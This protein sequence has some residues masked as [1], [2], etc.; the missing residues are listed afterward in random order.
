MRTQEIWRQGA[1]TVKNPAD[2]TNRCGITGQG[3]TY[4]Y[5]VR[6]WVPSG[7]L[8][9]RGFIVDNRAI[10][11]YWVWK[12]GSDQP[13]DVPSCEEIAERACQ[14]FVKL[15]AYEGVQLQGCEIRLYG[16]THSAVTVRWGDGVWSPATPIEDQMDPVEEPIEPGE[17]ILA[18]LERVLNPAPA[19]AAD[20]DAMLPPIDKLV[21]PGPLG[22][23]PKPAAEPELIPFGLPV[24]AASGVAEEPEWPHVEKALEGFYAGATKE[25]EMEPFP[26]SCEL[27][28]C[29]PT[30]QYPL[31]QRVG[32]A[33]IENG[34][35]ALLIALLV[36]GL[37]AN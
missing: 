13:T 4:R 33:V 34:T 11:L 9:G 31:W 12:Y 17:P 3:M 16:G 25:D 19:P 29:G 5:E 28:D 27:K 20:L 36:G 35:L 32:Q 7:T 14:D 8:N 37:L 21:A 22:F 30:W 1:F 18:H 10:N 26:G 23:P 6:L 15:M 2:V 24:E